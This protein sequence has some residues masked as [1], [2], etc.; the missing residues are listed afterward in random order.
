M[1][2]RIAFISDHASPLA[3]AGGVD[4]GGQNIYVAQV[5]MQLARLGYEVDVF[6]RRDSEALPEIVEWRP[7]VRVVHVPA[8][9]PRFVR[10][11]ALL[12]TMP[13]FAAWM[14]AFARRHGGY[15]LAHAKTTI[16]VNR[17]DLGANRM[18]YFHNAGYFEV[19][20]EDFRR[21]LRIRN[22][23]N[24]P[25]PGTGQVIVPGLGLAQVPVP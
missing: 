24:T 15:Q 1:A 19:E 8:G 6:T 11:E 2:K 9:P 20:G 10:K 16:G 17:I 23:T 25:G 5:A 3:A 14:G 13:D 22:T 21:V 18:G 7:H 4:S 12:A